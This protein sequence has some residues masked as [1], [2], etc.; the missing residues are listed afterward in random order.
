MFFPTLLAHHL[1]LGRLLLAGLAD[2]PRHFT[3]ASSHPRN[4]P[5]GT[6]AEPPNRNAVCGLSQTAIVIV[7]AQLEIS[8][9]TLEPSGLQRTWPGLHVGE[10]PLGMPVASHLSFFVLRSL[11]EAR[12]CCVLNKQGTA[13]PFVSHR[14][15]G[16]CLPLLLQ[17]LAYRFSGT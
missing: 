17:P 12:V 2:F 15:D 14:L 4:I 5:P 11:C 8:L 1:F 16:A 13:D 3:S 6:A 9:E 7:G 10:V